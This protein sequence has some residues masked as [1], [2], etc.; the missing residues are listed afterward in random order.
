V[1]NALREGSSPQVKSAKT[2]IIPLTRVAPTAIIYIMNTIKKSTALIAAAIFA[3]GIASTSAQTVLY[4]PAV[5]YAKESQQRT[6]NQHLSAIQSLTEQIK[7]LTISI[8]NSTKL[9]EQHT[10]KMQRDIEIMRRIGQKRQELTLELA[11]LEALTAQGE[12]F[13]NDPWVEA[14]TTQG[15]TGTTIEKIFKEMGS[16]GHSP[17]DKGNMLDGGVTLGSSRNQETGDQ[18]N[19]L[20]T[21]ATLHD[22]SFIYDGE[23]GLHV[24]TGTNSWNNAVLPQ[25]VMEGVV[26]NLQSLTGL[27]YNS[28]GFTGVNADYMPNVVG[29]GGRIIALDFVPPFANVMLNNDQRETL[30]GAIG[31]TA[32]FGREHYRR[33]TA[34]GRN[35]FEIAPGIIVRPRTEA[36]AL[37]EK[38]AALGQGTPESEAIFWASAA[39]YGGS[40]YDPARGFSKEGKFTPVVNMNDVLSGGAFSAVEKY[41]KSQGLTHNPYGQF[42]KTVAPILGAKLTGLEAGRKIHFTAEDVRRGEAASK[43][44][45]LSSI[46][47]PSSPEEWK[48]VFAR[49]E[50]MHNDWIKAQFVDLPVT[51]NISSNQTSTPSQSP[52]QNAADIF[53]GIGLGPNDTREYSSKILANSTRLSE[54]NKSLLV[55]VLTVKYNQ[56]CLAKVVELEEELKRLSD[57]ADNES[58]IEVLPMMRQNA[59]NTILVL[60]NRIAQLQAQVEEQLK[61]RHETMVNRQEIV[62]EYRDKITETGM[63]Q[64]ERLLSLL[65]PSGLGM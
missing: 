24:Q 6:H 14:L 49:S 9:T 42:A 12:V 55:T 59:Q 29:V 17:L 2:L 16:Y 45:G 10:N 60:Q 19:G 32:M 46:D 18:G 47:I 26:A 8:E 15:M 43:A 53:V 54:N 3:A 30:R 38:M 34:A 37:Y 21:D 52:T 11:R 23:F 58:I 41:N 20:N 28:Y 25:E 5:D 65:S 44:Q 40:Q 51:N 31:G 1:L 27:S 56:E 62:K 57:S 33:A 64:I 13:K 48:G 61:S 63:A 7:N 22:Q 50:K 35:P 4:V 36:D 39:V